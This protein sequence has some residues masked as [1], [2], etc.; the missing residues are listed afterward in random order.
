MIGE[1][2]AGLLLHAEDAHREPP[3]RAGDA[4][5]IKIER[6][7]V[8]RVDIAT[9]VH[10]HAGDDGKVSALHG[11]DQEPLRQPVRRDAAAGGIGVVAAAM[12]G[13]VQAAD[14]PVAPTPQKR[15]LR[16]AFSVAETGFDPARISDLYSR[17]V[18]AHM[19]E[20]P[21]AYDHLARPFK[22]KPSTAAAMPEISDDFKTFVVRVRPGIG[23]YHLGSQAQ[24]GI[25]LYMTVTLKDIEAAAGVE[26]A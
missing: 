13:L 23:G 2:D 10:F 17:I 20:A 22:L 8:R 15:V 19:F 26:A 24:G 11:N 5:A 16:Y 6:L 18:T 21:L 25:P 9:H 7:P 12:P 14:P 3:D 4:V 1:D